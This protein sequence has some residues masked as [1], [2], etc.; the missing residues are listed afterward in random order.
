MAKSAASA[1]GNSDS[2]RECSV[3]PH[4][5]RIQLDAPGN[6]S[7]RGGARKGDKPQKVD[8]KAVDRERF[9]AKHPAC[10]IRRLLLAGN[11]LGDGG[12]KALASALEKDRSVE[13]LD[14]TRY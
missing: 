6:V 7:N 5:R 3:E 12:A 14:L 13:V 2:D 11:R 4:G 9:P 1:A 10:G 8:E